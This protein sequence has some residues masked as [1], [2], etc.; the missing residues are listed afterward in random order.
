MYR[1]L[2]RLRALRLV[3]SFREKIQWLICPTD[4]PAMLRLLKWR[5]TAAK[6]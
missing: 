6:D 1:I 2:R 3:K 5:F 4:A